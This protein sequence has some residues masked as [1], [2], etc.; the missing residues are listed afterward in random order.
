MSALD[1]LG[2]RSHL[3]FNFD[4]A[5]ATEH[6]HVVTRRNVLGRPITVLDAQIVSVCVTC[7]AVLAILNAKDYWGCGVE[8]VNPW[9]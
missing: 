9:D 5:A 2:S 8:L 7:G 6:A 1:C 4:S 3:I